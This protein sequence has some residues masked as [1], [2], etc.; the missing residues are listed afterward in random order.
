MRCRCKEHEL[1]VD[2]AS[3]S[4]VVVADDAYDADEL[5]P[6]GRGLELE[7]M[8]DEQEREREREQDRLRPR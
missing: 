3:C 1:R 2:S 6:R 4:A 5:E 8:E 7:P